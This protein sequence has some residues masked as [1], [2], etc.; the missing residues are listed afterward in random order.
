MLAKQPELT[1]L[2][3][4]SAALSTAIVLQMGAITEVCTRNMSTDANGPLQLGASKSRFGHAEPGAGV[5]GLAEALQWLLHRRTPPIINL[6][7]IN[8]LVGSVLDAAKVMGGAAPGIRMHM[9]RSSGPSRS[10]TTNSQR[11][12]AAGISAF[13]F[14]VCAS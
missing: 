7:V 6:R 8:P 14:Q 4:F 1:Q 12:L 10:C 2:C 11:S 9:P 3:H 5:V 13:A